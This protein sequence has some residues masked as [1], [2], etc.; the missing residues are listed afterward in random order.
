MRNLK[1]N[2]VFFAVLLGLLCVGIASANGGGKDKAKNYEISVRSTTKVGAVVLK[3]GVYKFKVEGSNAIFTRQGSNTVFTTPAKLETVK[4]DFDNTMFHQIQD[5]GESR[6][7][8]IE[9]KGTQ[10]LLKF[11]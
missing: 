8:S 7:I 2:F 3:P 10:S 5:G 1:T 6:I 11:D 9:L 4:E